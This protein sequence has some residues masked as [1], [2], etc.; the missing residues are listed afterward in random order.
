MHICIMF[1]KTP[2][3]RMVSLTAPPTVL[4]NLEVLIRRKKKEKL[5]GHQL[6]YRAREGKIWKSVKE[7]R[8]H[9]T[10]SVHINPPFSLRRRQEYSVYIRTV[11]KDACTG[12][13]TER[14]KKAR[15]LF[16][17]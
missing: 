5:G 11:S 12:V 17:G 13:G 8:L 4:Q 10:Y 2:R 7:I 16:S 9:N 6:A 1:R 14:K 3:N 15:Y